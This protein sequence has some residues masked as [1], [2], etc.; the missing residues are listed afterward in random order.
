VDS[1]IL[2][3]ALLWACV[4]LS[5]DGNWL[6]QADALAPIL[7]LRDARQ[8]VLRDIPLRRLDGTGASKVRAIYNLSTRKSFIVVLSDLPELWEISYN[9]QAEPI[10]NGLVHDYK[11]GESLGTPGYLGVRRTL[12]DQPL[13]TLWF[14][15][16]QR[17]VV[18]VE[19]ASPEGEARARVV[20]LDVRRE[21]ARLAIAN[22]PADDAPLQ[23]SLGSH[24]LQVRALALDTREEAKRLQQRY[25][26]P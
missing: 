13:Q 9:P 24:T 17:Y 6:L 15:A 5:G 10:Y 26:T 3:Q 18:S 25:C 12:L 21:I 11:M 16:S 8:D 19:R 7:R 4:A 2:I 1:Q 14:D 20:N 23:L 22:W